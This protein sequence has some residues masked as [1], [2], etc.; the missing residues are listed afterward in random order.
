MEFAQDAS[1]E[2]DTD[3]PVRKP[4]DPRVRRTTVP[5]AIEMDPEAVSSWKEYAAGK[6]PGSD[7]GRALVVAAWHSEHRGGEAITPGH[8]YTCYRFMKWPV[9]LTDFGSPLRKLKQQQRLNS[10]GRGSYTITQIGLQDV[11]EMGAA[12]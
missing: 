10:A 4:K 8:V 5:K 1:T 11:E 6:D 2:G 12:S 7:L 3:E 9:G